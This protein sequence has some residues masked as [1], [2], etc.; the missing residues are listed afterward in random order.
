MRTPQGVGQNDLPVPPPGA[1][2]SPGPNARVQDYLIGQANV[3]AFK[4]GRTVEESHGFLIQRAPA[5]PRIKETPR[6]CAGIVLHK[7]A[8]A[9]REIRP[10]FDQTVLAQRG[11]EE[12]GDAR[13]AKADPYQRASGIF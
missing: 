3:R 1:Q 12:P 2:A 8:P 4:H 11:A 13:G 9:S 5:A 6:C 10:N 7:R